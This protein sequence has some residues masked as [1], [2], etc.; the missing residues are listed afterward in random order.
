[1]HGDQQLEAGLLAP[2]AAVTKILEEFDA[3]PEFESL[4]NCKFGLMGLNLEA[5]QKSSTPE[6]TLRDQLFGEQCSL[7]DSHDYITRLNGKSRR[8]AKTMHNQLLR[9]MKLKKTAAAANAAGTPDSPEV[10]AEAESIFEGL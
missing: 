2:R 7:K 5:L 10:K 6:E 4:P 9:M 8:I 3:F 1:M